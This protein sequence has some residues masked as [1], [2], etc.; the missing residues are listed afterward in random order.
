MLYT[1][2]ED[3]TELTGTGAGD[4]T[5]KLN[6]WRYNDRQRPLPV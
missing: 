1:I 2:D 5:I 4:N 3:L 6:V